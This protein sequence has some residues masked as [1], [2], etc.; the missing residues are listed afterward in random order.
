MD[1]QPYHPAALL[2][3]GNAVLSMAFSKDETSLAAGM[4]NGTILIWNRKDINAKPREILGRHVSGITALAFSQDCSQLASASY[5]HTLKLAGFPNVEA[6]PISIENHES[7]VYDILFTPDNKHLISCSA[8]KTIRVNSTENAMMAEALKK[9]L[10]RNMTLEEWK[11]MV[12]SDI[13]YKNT[14]SDLP[15]Y[16]SSNKQTN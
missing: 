8:D 11:K 1:K 5:D 2:A 9:K 15:G 6:N 12:G 7:W 13:P 14:R 4:S 16:E 10:T 3:S